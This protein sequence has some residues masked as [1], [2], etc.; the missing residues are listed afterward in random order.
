MLPARDTSVIVRRVT[1]QVRD[2]RQDCRRV[3]LPPHVRR[4]FGN[5]DPVRI[6]FLRGP[7][8]VPPSRSAARRG[9]FPGRPARAGFSTRTRYGPSE[10]SNCSPRWGF[11]TTVA[12]WGLRPHFS[13]S[14]T[15]LDKILTL[16]G[17]LRR[18]R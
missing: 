10:S 8:M 17:F 1:G 14:L 16:N 5:S 13:Y 6:G 9:V 2:T 12:F 4:E 3:W 15:L 18:C 11:L 7:G